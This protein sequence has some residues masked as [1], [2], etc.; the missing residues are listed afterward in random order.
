MNWKPFRYRIDVISQLNRSKKSIIKIM[1][2][3]TML[4]CDVIMFDNMRVVLM[5]ENAT[6]NPSLVLGI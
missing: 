4:L 5:V 3:T 2:I 6:T 1:A